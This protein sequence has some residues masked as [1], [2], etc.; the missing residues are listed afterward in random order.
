MSRLNLEKVRY[1]LEQAPLLVDQ[2]KGQAGRRIDQGATEML[3]V[4]RTCQRAALW[5]TGLPEAPQ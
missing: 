4:A 1:A 5:P 2:L 3:N